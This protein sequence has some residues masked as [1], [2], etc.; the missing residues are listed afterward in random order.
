MDEVAIWVIQ[1][2]A[3]DGTWV[4]TV[5]SFSRD[6]LKE[7]LKLTRRY[8]NGEYRIVK[9]YIGPKSRKRTE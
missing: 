2:K 3:G 5:P 8:F 7:V 4:Y 6:E 1:K 9:R